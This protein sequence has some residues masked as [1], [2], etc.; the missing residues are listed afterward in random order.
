MIAKNGPMSAPVNVLSDVTDEEIAD[1]LAVAE[2]IPGCQ[3]Y[4]AYEY[5]GY[6]D[7][8]A[9]YHA[10]ACSACGATSIMICSVR[11]GRHET[12]IVCNAVGYEFK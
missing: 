12:C 5:I 10:W 1:K 9:G 4:H 11:L 8:A 6:S 7:T 3:K 2:P